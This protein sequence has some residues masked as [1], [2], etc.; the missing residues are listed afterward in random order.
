MPWGRLDDSLYDHPKLDLLPHEAEAAQR[1]LDTLDPA[2]LVKLVAL[3]L[4]ARSISWCNRFLTDG[5]VPRATIVRK[6]DGSPE[7]AD[8]MV[9]AGWFESSATGYQ[10]HDFLDF[11][12][13]RADVLERREKDADR[14]REWRKNRGKNRHGVSHDVTSNGSEP[15]VTG[16]VTALVTPSSRARDVARIPARPGPAESNLSGERIS[17][18]RARPRRADIQA[19]HDRG[20]KRV[21]KAQRQV[22]DEVLDRHDV[23]GPAFAA[24]V[25]RATPAG[26]DPLEAV[27]AADRLWQEARRRQ[28]DA[29]EAAAKAIHEPV[30]AWLE[31]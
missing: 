29:D 30:P 3:G 19:L 17:D 5:A 13:S 23:T 4:W 27:M 6:L 7:L 8:A 16:G 14:Q 21:T 22:L 20:W 10:V 11:N 2:Q 18:A 12:E 28:A 9:G 26:R 15:D 1:I 31:R 24:E 25:I